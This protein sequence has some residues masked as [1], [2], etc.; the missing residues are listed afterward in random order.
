MWVKGNRGI[1]WL[2]G[3]SLFTAGTNLNVGLTKLST[4]KRPGACTGGEKEREGGAVCTEHSCGSRAAEKQ[5]IYLKK[6]KQKASKRTKEN[7]GKMLLGS[8]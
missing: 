3:A 2:Q 6:K 1:V 7:E 5:G 8:S 4:D